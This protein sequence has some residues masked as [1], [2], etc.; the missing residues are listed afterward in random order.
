MYKLSDLRDRDVINIC[1]GRRL[2]VIID[3]DVDPDTGRIVSLICPGGGKLF[4]FFGS[5]KDHVIPWEKVVRIG[6]DV[7]LVDVK[8]FQSFG[9][10]SEDIDGRNVIR[11]KW[12]TRGE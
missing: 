4:G 10:C 9:S 3:I 11:G 12:L 2:G 7:I 1:D 8:S 5:G 6:P